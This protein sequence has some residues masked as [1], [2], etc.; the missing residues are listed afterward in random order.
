[1]LI[2]FYAWRIRSFSE[3]GKKRIRDIETT[4]TSG[5]LHISLGLKSPPRIQHKDGKTKVNPTGANTSHELKRS[6][7]E[8]LSKDLFNGRL[9]HPITYT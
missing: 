7:S 9:E 6:P 8:E 3:G 4:R 1:M 5:L 2:A